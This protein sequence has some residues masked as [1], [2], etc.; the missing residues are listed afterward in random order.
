MAFSIRKLNQQDLVYL[1]EFLHAVFHIRNRDKTSL[2]KWKYFH[3][4]IEHAIEYGAF[5]GT[6]LVGHYANIPIPLRYGGHVVDAMLCIDMATHPSYRG[7]GLISRLSEFVYRDVLHTSAA[8]SLGFSNS[9]GMRVDLN[10]RSYGYKVIGAFRS[11]ALMTRRG[12][13]PTRVTHTEEID[14]IPFSIPDGY[15]SIHKSQEYL[16]WRYHDH[17]GSA[18]ELYR[19]SGDAIHGYVVLRVSRFRIDIIDIALSNMQEYVV[20]DVIHAIQNLAAIQRKQ[21][22]VIGVLE[23]NYW[24]RILKECMGVRKPMKESHYLTVRIH[25]DHHIGPDIYNKE[26]WICM[27]GDIL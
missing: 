5:D 27:T 2:I 4:F 24:R 20:R 16:K 10:A 7:L 13:S 19:V 3:P 6:R 18:Y 12:I 14:P 26:Q 11:Y 8:L 1:I 22:V 25:N 17:P 21:M 23:N 15:I 9:Q